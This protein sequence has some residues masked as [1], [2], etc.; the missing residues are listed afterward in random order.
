VGEAVG[1]VAVVVDTGAVDTAE[2]VDTVVVDTEAVDTAE[3]VDTAVVDTEG[4]DTA[5][6]VDTAVVDTEAVDTAVAEEAA[7]AV[8]VAAM[9]VVV[10]VVVAA[11]ADITKGALCGPIALLQET[12][13]D[14]S[15]YVNN[16]TTRAA[17]FLHILYTLRKVNAPP[18]LIRA[19]VMYIRPILEHCC[20]LLLAGLILQQVKQ[21]E[22]I[23]RRVRW[24]TRYQNALDM[25]EP[26]TLGQKYEDLCLKF[27]HG[28]LEEPRHYDLLQPRRQEVSA[29]VTRGSDH[30]E[31]LCC[32]TRFR[33]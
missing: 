27:D 4:V 17:K 5:E 11:V 32:G 15:N 30:V 23:Q 19:Y 28:L 3:V 31:N 18:Q 21:T 1:M 16:I 26:T 9:V 13:T 24:N 33:K 8:V 29:T 22:G 25:F 6:V 20:P 12:P 14:A 2:A 10:D 7:M